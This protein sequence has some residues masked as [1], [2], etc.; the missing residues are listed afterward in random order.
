[1]RAASRV[2]SFGLALAAV[3]GAGATVGR[4]VGPIDVGNDAGNGGGA[5]HGGGHGA[6]PATGTRPLPA[7]GLLVS[8]DGYT[9]RTGDRVLAADRPAPFAFRIEGPDGRPLRQYQ[10]Q[11]DREL[12]LIVVSRDLAEFAHVHPERDAGGTWSV[13]LPPVPPGAY[14]AYADFQPAG[15]APLTLG[16]DLAVPG[17]VAAPAPLVQRRHA[18]VDGYDVTLDGD[19]HPAGSSEVTVTVRRGGQVVTT[20]PYLGAAGHLVAVR[21]G[22]LAY[23]HVHPLDE[24]PAGPVRFA[25]E[26]PSRG[27]Y[28]LYFDFLHDGTVRTAAFTVATSGTPRAAPGGHGH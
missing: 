27:T 15:H 13:E 19:V 23:L 4:A 8:Q 22:D 6:G 9:L 18:E 26:A 12:H 14:R 1:M 17:P 2:A 5:D 25:V 16:I 3:L 7:G 10:E 21:D 28:G 11:H 20:Q 24:E